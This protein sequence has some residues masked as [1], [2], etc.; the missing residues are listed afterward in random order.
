ML[1]RSI[2][3]KNETTAVAYGVNNAGDIAVYATN[4]SGT[5]DSFLYN[6]KTFKKINDPKAKGT[7]GTVAHAPNN[8]GDVTGTYYD[9][10]G[11]V[12]GWLLHAGKYYDVN[13]PKGA[14]DSRSDGINDK[15]EM[16]GRYSTTL[17]GASIGFKATTK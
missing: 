8:K 14:D 6:G 13:D 4:S 5:F 15:L 9:S 16:V 11:N 12:H 2:D 1:F 7:T 10:D 3:V 17:G